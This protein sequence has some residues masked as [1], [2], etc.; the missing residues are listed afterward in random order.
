MRGRLLIVEDDK[1]LAKLVGLHA[2]EVGLTAELAFDGDEGLRKALAGDYALIILDCMLPGRDGLEIC[3]AIRAKDKKVPLLM[4]TARAEEI[5][6]VLAFELG[7]DDYLTKPFGVRELVVR[8]KA[9]LR[10]S[11]EGGAPEASVRIGA[12]EIQPEKRRATVRGEPI[13]LT[14]TEY[15]LLYLLASNAG[16]PF[17]R[18]ELL[19]RV[20]E[21]RAPNYA[22]TV[23][24]HINRLRSKIEEN[25]AEPKYI[26]TVWGVG[27]RFAEAA[28]VER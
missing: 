15:D 12:V 26:L 28:E 17:T 10:R 21:Y 25:P 9:L 11:A 20:W 27:Y 2:A 5:D 22:H 3:R 13:E 19:D 18:E 23:T 24:S 14:S 16:K 6:K 8:M 1:D 7:V 4:L